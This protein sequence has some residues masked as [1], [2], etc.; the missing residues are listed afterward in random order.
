M[1][2]EEF[3]LQLNSGRIQSP[4]NSHDFLPLSILDEKITRDRVE[5]VLSSGALPCTPSLPDKVCQQAKKVFAILV[6]IYFPEAITELFLEGLTDEHLPL[7]RAPQGDNNY[8]N[9]Y[10]LVSVRG[11]TFKAFATLRNPARVSDFLEKQWL[12]Q[13][14]ML[15]TSG[16]HIELDA[17]C[18]LPFGKVDK[19]V[20]TD[21]STVWKGA[22]HPAHQQG[23][24]VSEP[25]STHM[26]LC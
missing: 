18:A 11:K 19:K 2:T 16:K 25:S 17:K 24:K 8:H 14:P 20:A 22:L 5:E 23:L 3:Y 9:L 26:D 15:D 21:F 1:A 12:V 6:L 13:A 10:Y 7:C 4:L